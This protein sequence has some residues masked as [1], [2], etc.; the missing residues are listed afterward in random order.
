LRTFVVGD[1][2]GHA[3][4]LQRLM[5][6]LRRMA[7]RGDSLVFIGDYVDRGPRSRQVVDQVLKERQTWKGPVISLKGNHEAMMLEAL[8][9]YQTQGMPEWN[10]LDVASGRATIASYT[11]YLSME[12][13][14]RCL[15]EAHRRFFQELALWHADENGIYVH[16]GIPPGKQPHDCGEEDLLWIRE[17]FIDS[18]YSWG[19]P[20]VFGHTPQFAASDGGLDLANVLWEPLNR[21]EKI[22]IDTGCAYGGPLTTVVL[23]E[24]EFVDSNWAPF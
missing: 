9:T 19:K 23:P 6:R 1:I 12:A 17:R 16:A 21:P 10:W 20:V 2:H 14:D 4:R 8:A 15:P 5:K 11:D 24:R 7:A 13:F 3:D 22:G 18:D